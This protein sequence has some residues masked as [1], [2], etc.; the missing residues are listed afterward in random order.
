VPVYF[1]RA[2]QTDLVK[3]GFAWDPDRRLRTL[4]SANAERLHIIEK[5]PGS[6]AVERR[7]HKALTRLGLHVRG[8]WFRIAGE[9]PDDIDRL[10]KLVARREAGVVP[11]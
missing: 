5:V 1:V 3:V 2:G 6:R 8:E 7:F 9:A 4:Q 10:E 11:C